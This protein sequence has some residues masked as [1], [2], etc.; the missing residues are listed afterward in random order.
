MTSITEFLQR[1]LSKTSRWL[2]VVAALAL[3]PAIVL[4]TWTITLHAPQYPDGLQVVIYPHTVGGDLSE[5][6]LLNH[7]I[8]MQEIRPDE[9]AEF[10]FIPFFILRFLGFAL[11]TALVGRMPI[12]A[13]GWMD[14]ALFGVVMLYTF[15][16]WLHAFGTNLS[17]DA[18][19]SIEPFSPAFIGTTRIGQFGVESWPAAGA[20]L[21]GIAGLLGPVIVWWEWRGARR[22]GTD[23]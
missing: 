6:N 20:I 10:R 15:Q 4:P 14:F 8:G 9:F 12:A 11:L 2:I 22:G 19:L 13:I 1:Q 17:P 3:L 16:R 5:V 21:M 7:Y 18:P 23:R